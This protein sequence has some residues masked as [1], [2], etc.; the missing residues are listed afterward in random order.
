MFLTYENEAHTISEF[1]KGSMQNSSLT[2]F[3][4]LIVCG[5]NMLGESTIW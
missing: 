4:D 1:G 2:I 3:H 5:V